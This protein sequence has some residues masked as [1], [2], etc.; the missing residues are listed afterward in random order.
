MNLSTPSTNTKSSPREDEGLGF[1]TIDAITFCQCAMTLDHT[2]AAFA[3]S[4]RW[5]RY[6][7][8]VPMLTWHI[9]VHLPIVLLLINPLSRRITWQGV[10][11]DQRAV[12]FW[13]GNLM[14][15]FGFRI[16]RFGR[17]HQGACLSVANHVSWL[18]ITLIHSQRVVNF[19]AKSEISRWPLIGWLARRAG[20]I[21]HRRG[22]TD[23]LNAVA[24]LMVQRLREAE[25]VGVFP[26]GGSSTSF[27]VRTFHA[28]IFQPALDAAIP[29]QPIALRY[30][31]NAEL[32]HSVPF[33]EE[34]SFLSNFLRLLGEAGADAEVHFLAAIDSLNQPRRNLAMNA[35]AAIAQTV[36]M[37]DAI[38][39]AGTMQGETGI[40]V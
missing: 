32:A 2:N 13:Q 1:I 5:W 40:E 36:G 12:M 6:S 27:V 10:R 22:S 3:S 20:T 34:E 19:V 39:Q 7:W 18:D 21:Y 31:R 23:S 4:F 8:R 30:V 11:L 24:D 37:P 28:R 35:R 29:V 9:L 25:S 33:R 38:I 17:P 14:R 16:K 15:I 26:E